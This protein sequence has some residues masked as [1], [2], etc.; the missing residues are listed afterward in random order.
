MALRFRAS[1]SPTDADLTAVAA[2]PDG[3]FVAVGRRGTIIRSGAGGTRWRA[4]D[5]PVSDD[6][7]AV[8]V[9]GD[10]DVFIV[11]NRGVFV[12]GPIEGPFE[13]VGLRTDKSL[14]GVAG[15]GERVVIVGQGSKILVSPDGGG[16]FVPPRRK[17]HRAQSIVAVT[18][19]DSHV[20]AVG[21]F[22]GPPWVCRETN[23]GWSAQ[24]VAA[25]KVSPRELKKAMPPLSWPGGFSGIRPLLSVAS[26]GDDCVAVGRSSLC[27]SSRDGGHSFATEE[28]PTGVDLHAV[29]SL[30]D[31]RDV[32]VGKAGTLLVRD[33]ARWRRRSLGERDLY[34]LAVHDAQ[35][36]AVGASGQILRGSPH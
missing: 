6:L 8:W 20:L 28:V 12:R 13:R 11:G 30:S 21:A 33:D 31:G 27:V 23:R 15:N 22:Y 16:S 34:G 7:N 17:T 26:R 18:F 32:V 5:S 29:V 2:C 10:G 24:R 9:D 19:I 14:W 3:R 25:Q 4:V 1:K 35:L 36:V